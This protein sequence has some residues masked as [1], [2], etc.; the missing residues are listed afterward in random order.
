MRTP[1][2]R[3][4]SGE[5]PY[6]INDAQGIPLC[7]VCHDCQTERLKQYRP[8]I[9]SG[10]SQDDVCEPIEPDGPYPGEEPW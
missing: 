5:I 8:E 2:C 10:Y 9:L 7:K 6:W 1:P 4:G 3:C